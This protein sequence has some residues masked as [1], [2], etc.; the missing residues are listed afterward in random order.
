MFCLFLCCID[1]E[2]ILW[3]ASDKLKCLLGIRFLWDCLVL[4]STSVVLVSQNNVNLFFASVYE[5]VNQNIQS[6][7]TL[8]SET[9]F[10]GMQ[11]ITYYKIFGEG[12]HMYTN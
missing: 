9:L 7:S 1:G 6:K 3:S 12:K 4:L 2:L 10:V 8:T 11:T 5:S